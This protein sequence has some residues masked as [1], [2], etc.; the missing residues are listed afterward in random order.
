MATTTRRPAPL[1]AL[2][3]LAAA[4]CWPAAAAD[5]RLTPT[6]RLREGYSDNMALGP[7]AQARAEFSGEIAPGIA[8][9]A[10]GPRLTLTLDYALQRLAYSRSP[11]RL[12]HQLDAAGHAEALADW[13]YVD[14]QASVGRQNISAFGP[15]Q[16]DP[17]QLG[18][19]SSTV[20][21]VGLSPYLKHHFRGLAEA[22][23]RYTY[24]ASS[25]GALL[26]AH[27]QQASLRLVGDNRA[28][29]WNW[30]AAVDQRQNND[31]ALAP[32][33]QRDATLTLRLP[34]RPRLSWFASAGRES[35]DYR[36]LAGAPGGRH[37][38]SGL[39]W[40]PSPRSS[41]AASVGRRHFGNT[42]SLDARHQMRHLVLTLGYSEDITTSQQ[43]L[44]R[45]P[46]AD[47]GNFLY[48]LW[49]GRIPDPPL[50]IQVI[51]AFLRHSRLQGPNAGNVN[52]LSHN[53]FLQKQW[54]L[55]ALYSTPKSTL[56]PG[57][58]DSRRSA[59]TSSAIDSPLLGPAA[60]AQHGSS[61][62]G[63]YRENGAA[64]TLSVLF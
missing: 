17:A 29:G 58:A 52:Y 27:S 55:S 32:V 62:G 53:Y 56:A 23:L 44:Q 30:E 9:Q 38:S 13:L 11:S 33:T 40:T 34:L 45:L 35:S 51:N 25:S 61:A 1:A 10:R 7:P 31:A 5:W 60:L 43:Q 8:V 16:S 12:N 36:A 54:N 49:A 57:L 37:W 63:G 48:Q 19:N 18:G 26:R 28:G 39:S 4:R 22:E 24:Q 64:A 15:Q 47:L 41:V 21:S 46:P 14:G 42:Y 50:R 2:A 3:A 20:R 6:L 59:Q